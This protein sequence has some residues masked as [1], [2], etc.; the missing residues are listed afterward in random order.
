M[1]PFSIGHR[2]L[3]KDAGILHCDIS[4]QNIMRTRIP[5]AKASDSKGFLIDFDYAQQQYPNCEQSFCMTGTAPFIALELLLKPQVYHTWRHD[6]ESFLYVL[7]WLCTDNPYEKLN[8]WVKGLEHRDFVKAKY[9]DVT[10]TGFF[11]DV[12]N[13]FH[14]RFE[15]LKGLSLAFKEILFKD[16]N[17]T[18]TAGDKNREDIYNKVIQIFDDCVAKL[19]STKTLEKKVPEEL[20]GHHDK[21]VEA[22]GEG[23]EYVERETGNELSMGECG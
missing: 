3:Y 18:T 14:V 5:I 17:M 20:A 13:G 8:A 6:L 10:T 11:E 19:E 22:G 16:S 15:P 21:G 9:L 2:S 1:F 7:I 12:L 4:V 23:W